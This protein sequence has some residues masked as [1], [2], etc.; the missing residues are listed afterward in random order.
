MSFEKQIRA[1][2]EG[3]GSS[4]QA[5]DLA[6]KSAR[7]AWVTATAAAW[8]D[9]QRE[10]DERCGEAVGRLSEEDF[11]RLCDTEQ[12]KVDAA[13]APLQAAADRDEWPRELYWGG[14]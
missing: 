9:A 13:R 3:N 5:R 14:V 12:A 1:L 4:E 11:E 2:L 8:R 6:R 10:M 7:C